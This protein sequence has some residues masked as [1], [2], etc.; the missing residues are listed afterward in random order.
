MAVIR[1][2]S[3]GIEERRA[4]ELRRGAATRRWSRPSAAELAAARH[5]RDGHAQLVR[6]GLEAADVMFEYDRRINAV[7]AEINGLE[8]ETALLR[9]RLQDDRRGQ[10]GRG[11][12]GGGGAEGR[13]ATACA[14]ARPWCGSSRSSADGRGRTPAGGRCTGCCSC[15]PRL[16]GRCGRGQRARVSPARRQARG[17]RLH[18]GPGGLRRQPRRLAR[19]HAREAEERGAGAVATCRAGPVVE[20]RVCLEADPANRAN[21]LRWSTSRGPD[22]PM[23]AGRAVPA[24]ARG[25]PPPARSPS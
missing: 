5:Q 8:R 6:Q 7:V 1:R 18:P 15:P 14:R 13:P 9:T 20:V 2:D 10:G 22:R 12:P 16:P 19:G 11:R 25:G 23:G 24:V 4:D 17:V 3:A 21:G